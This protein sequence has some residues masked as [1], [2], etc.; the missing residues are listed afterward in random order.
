MCKLLPEHRV[1]EHLIPRHILLKSIDEWQYW[2]PCTFIAMK[3]FTPLTHNEQ[4]NIYHIPRRDSSSHFF[5]ADIYLAYFHCLATPIFQKRQ[6][7]KYLGLKIRVPQ[8]PHFLVLTIMSPSESFATEIFLT[9]LQKF[10]VSEYHRGIFIK[11]KFHIK[12]KSFSA[13]QL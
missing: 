9:I 6:S 8:K 12:V 7:L 1:Q 13:Y 2:I 5:F 10:F 3:V 11:R 4:S